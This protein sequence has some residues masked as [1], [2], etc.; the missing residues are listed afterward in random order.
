M[1]PTDSNDATVKASRPE[2]NQSSDATV[3]V[4]GPRPSSDGDATRVEPMKSSDDATR[5]GSSD[6]AWY[7]AGADVPS[8]DSSS[9]HGETFGHYRL[10]KLLGRGG[11]GAVFA[12]EDMRLKRRVALKIQSGVGLDNG[13]LSARFKLEAEIASRLDH[14]GICTVYDVGVIDD[15]PYIAM[16]LV[17]GKS[18]GAELAA[19]RDEKKQ[20]SDTTGRAAAAGERSDGGNSSAVSTK[21]DLLRYVRIIAKAARAMHVAHAAGIIHRDI[22]PGNIMIGHDDEPVILDFGL[23]RDLEGDGASLT[24]SGDFLG[25]P[26]YMSPEQVT[27]GRVPMDRRTDVYSLG[28]TLYECLTLAKPFREATYEALY[29]AIRTK[30]PQDPRK[31]NPRISADLKTILDTALSKDLARR[32]QTAESFADDLEAILDHRPI[33][34]KKVGAVGKAVRFTRREPVK[35]ALI[36]VLF[37]ATPTIVFL[38][39]REALT[40]DERE[41]G[42]LAKLAAAKDAF[43]SEGFFEL[44]EGG[45]PRVAVDLFHR[46]RAL[47]GGSLEAT[48]GLAMATWE[49]AKNPEEVLAILDSDP[50]TNST[51][52]AKNLR[53]DML[54]RM[55]RAAD[56]AAI[57]RGITDPETEVDWYLAGHYAISR[58][59]GGDEGQFA[60]A[61]RAFTQAVLSASA[62][63]ALYFSERVHAAGHVRDVDAVIETARVIETRWPNLAIPNYYAGYALGCIRRCD[64]AQEFLARADRASPDDARTLAKIGE[65]HMHAGRHD[66]AV[67]FLQR[68]VAIRP[69]DEFTQCYLFESLDFLGKKEEADRAIEA[70]YRI[71]PDSPD[72]LVTRARTIK[73]KG[74]RDEAEKDLLRAIELAPNSAA[75]WGSLGEIV[76]DRKDDKKAAELFGKAVAAQPDYLPAREALIWCLKR[77][78]RDDEAAEA[79]VEFLNQNPDGPRSHYVRNLRA[80]WLR[81]K[82]R[83]DE[84]M[85][86]W[87]KILEKRPDDADAIYSIGTA[88]FE[89]E[90]LDEAE[91]SFRACIAIAPKHWMAHQSLGYVFWKRGDYE[92]AHE[93]I[94][95]ATLCDPKVAE[96]VL[97]LGRLERGAK[98]WADAAGRFEKVL[99]LS[100]EDTRAMTLLADCRRELELFEESFEWSRRYLERV[101]DDFEERLLFGVALKRAGRTI[102]S[103]RELEKVV[104]KVPEKG[105]AWVNLGLDYLDLGRGADA[106]SAFRRAE[107]LGKNNPK[108]NAPVA[109]W[110]ADAERLIE[111]EKKLLAALESGT[112][113]TDA[114]ELVGHAVTAAKTRRRVVAV[115]LFRAAEKADPG[116]LARKTNSKAAALAASAAAGA[117]VG[118]SIDAASMT[119]DEKA[120]FEVAARDWLGIVVKNRRAEADDLEKPSADFVRSVEALRILSPYRELREKT[121]D[122]T[123]PAADRSAWGGF[124]NDID[125][126]AAELR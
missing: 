49:V 3:R 95:K 82:N 52:A 34:A 94:E 1:T 97:Q 68:S 111:S 18:L 72:I 63:R 58:G 7:S 41:T 40:A 110:I 74:R 77:L 32:Y 45:R 24:R 51:F 112:L 12:A 53:H 46:C 20:D 59:H 67:P 44:G 42:R 126:F 103:A 113:P 62:P 99:E 50:S 119:P 84:A 65:V 124:W 39:T 102:E 107:E 43:L 31:L 60:V 125:E 86:E 4:D 27:G 21:A 100:P 26:A 89:F 88:H 64:R 56:A 13:A 90:R 75:A 70:A 114:A 76:E 101:P 122:P 35:A 121:L 10:T 9:S 87:R 108:W 105:S 47:E 30:E 123:R 120:S 19:L 61:L 5:A 69:E 83:H 85:A 29:A 11:Q 66:L 2:P 109:D 80:D 54:D 14:P 104:A 6:S 71:R 17:E 23:A 36:A 37:L 115:R 116:I 48:I 92:H 55:G 79:S 16:R 57:A 81:S 8:G 38:L 33:A 118:E 22:K 117:V 91:K 78:G 15:T 106:V 73:A 96:P 98:K 93:W 25:T 28:A